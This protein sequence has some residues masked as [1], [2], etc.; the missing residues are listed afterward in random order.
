M[1]KG[2][3]DN[4]L[5]IEENIFNSKLPE[6][7]VKLPDSQN[8]LVLLFKD[9]LSDVIITHTPLLWEML[10]NLTDKTLQFTKEDKE[11]K[12]TI[13]VSMEKLNA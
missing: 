13:A 7:K 1:E 11:Y 3:I 9:N 2:K 8:G 10:K 5:N 6:V 4:N 12:L